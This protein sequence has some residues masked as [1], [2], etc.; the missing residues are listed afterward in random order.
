MA[1]IVVAC[2]AGL[3]DGTDWSSGAAV[4]GDHHVEAAAAAASGAHLPTTPLY[5]SS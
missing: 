4:G 3:P 5:V 2:V 1:W